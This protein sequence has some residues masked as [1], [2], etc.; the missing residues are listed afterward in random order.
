MPKE[1]IRKCAADLEMALTDSKLVH[2]ADRVTT[3]KMADIDGFMLREEIETK[4]IIP[5]ELL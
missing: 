2:A 1:T 3:M 4:P 5:S